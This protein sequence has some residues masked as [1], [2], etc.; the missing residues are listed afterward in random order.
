MEHAQDLDRVGLH[1]VL[2]DERSLRDD[3]FAGARYAARPP[4]F[5]M[6]RQEL[7]DGMDDVQSDTPRGGRVV[8]GDVG[9]KRNKVSDRLGRPDWGHARERLGTGRSFLVPHE[10]IQSL[11]SWCA[12]LSPRSSDAIACLT[13]ATC[14]S[15]T[16]R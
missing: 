6:F 1:A 10:A 7:F 8:F 15:L 11:T 4:H 12:I 3:E 16:V 2:H 9:A 13:P 14:H 5:P